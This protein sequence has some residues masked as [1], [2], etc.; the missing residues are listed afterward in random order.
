MTDLQLK[1]LELLQN[2]ISRMAQNSFT[3]KG[4]AVTVVAALLAL[5]NK[6]S[7]RLFAAYALYPAVAFWGLD[8]YYLMQERLFRKLGEQPAV[9]GQE[10]DFKTKPTVGGFFS[11][12]FSPTVLPLYAF[13]VMMAL[14]IAF[15]AR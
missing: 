7:D 8:A 13:S 15:F 11:A 5:S 1:R 14:L 9:F 4:W 10:L 12:A 3:I 6:D 2:I